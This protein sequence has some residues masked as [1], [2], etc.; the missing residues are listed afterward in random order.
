MRTRTVCGLLSVVFVLG[1]AAGGCHCPQDALVHIVARD[2]EVSGLPDE[3][4]LPIGREGAVEAAR[5]HGLKPGVRPWE[6]H[7]EA[8]LSG[9][10]AWVITNTEWSY[11]GGGTGGVSMTVSAET[12]ELLRSGHWEIRFSDSTSPRASTPAETAN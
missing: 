5:A 7:L 3:S 9:G 1:F 12:G 10:W 11:R 2:A 4:L 6:I 8:E